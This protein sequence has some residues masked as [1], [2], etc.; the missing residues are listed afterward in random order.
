MK[1]NSEI[2]Y[3]LESVNEI[4]LT[5]GINGKKVIMLRKNDN[6]IKFQVYTIN[7]ENTGTLVANISIT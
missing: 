6:Y 2:N 4:V 1:E 5:R 3:E 7:D